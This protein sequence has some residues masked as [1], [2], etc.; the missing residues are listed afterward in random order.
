MVNSKLDDT[1]SR[2]VAFDPLIQPLSTNDF[3]PAERQMGQT[4][5]SQELAFECVLHMSLGATE[6]VSYFADGQ[7]A[8]DLFIH[9]LN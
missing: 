2:L 4:W 9:S 5:Q 7:D 8:F 3:A 6:Q 1:L